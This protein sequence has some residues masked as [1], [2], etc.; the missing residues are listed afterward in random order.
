MLKEVRLGFGGSFQW[1]GSVD[2]DAPFHAPK[3][4]N[5]ASSSLLHSYQWGDQ[6]AVD[7]VVR[8]GNPVELRDG[9]VEPW[10][11][12]TVTSVKADLGTG[13]MDMMAPP[14]NKARVL[15]LGGFTAIPDWW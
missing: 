10:K 13:L 1:R 15:A 3:L 12:A 14:F 8:I 2:P 11:N 4:P 6:R 9:L 5:P 7:E